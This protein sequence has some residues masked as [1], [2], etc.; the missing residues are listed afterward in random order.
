MIGK[1]TPPLPAAEPQLTTETE[2]K[3]AVNVDYDFEGDKNSNG[4]VERLK[5]ASFPDLDDD[6]C[7]VFMISFTKLY[8]Y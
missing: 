3:V 5:T 8:P 1:T 6:E 4:E 2:L 7:Q